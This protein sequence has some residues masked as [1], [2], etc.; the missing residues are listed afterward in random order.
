MPKHEADP[1][2]PMELTGVAVPG[3]ARHMAACLVE[4]YLLMGF[5]DDDVLALFRSPEYGAVHG[6]YE[7]F[8]EPYIRELI[9]SV[10]DMWQAG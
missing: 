4:E 10:R 6:L 2:D 5:T 7:T 1:S 9:T 8:G 3:D